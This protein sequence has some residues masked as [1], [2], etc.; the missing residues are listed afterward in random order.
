MFSSLLFSNLHNLHFK[1][2][3]RAPV[4]LSRIAAHSALFRPHV[5][6]RGLMAHGIAEGLLNAPQMLG[7]LELLFNPT[8]LVQVSRFAT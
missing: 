1:Y 3:C 8:G 4:T 5:L 6:V 7:S 2:C